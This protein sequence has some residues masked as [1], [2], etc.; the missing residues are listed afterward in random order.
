MVYGVSRWQGYA[1]KKRYIIIIIG[2]SVVS[3]YNLLFF[4]EIPQ[5]E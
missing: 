2:N 1:E 5:N 3:L 4:R